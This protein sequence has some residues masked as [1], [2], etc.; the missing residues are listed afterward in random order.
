[1]RLL[2]LSIR[3]RVKIINAASADYQLRNQAEMQNF[4]RIIFYLLKNDLFASVAAETWH[5]FIIYLDLRTRELHIKTFV[6]SLTALFK[7]ITNIDIWQRSSR[8]P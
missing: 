6:I 7:R 8:R 2:L 3:D 1:M 4:D 5:I